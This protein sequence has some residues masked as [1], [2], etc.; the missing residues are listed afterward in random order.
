MVN[1]TERNLTKIKIVSF[2]FISS[3]LMISA[4]LYSQTPEFLWVEQVLDGANDNGFDLVVD[5]AGHTVICGNYNDNIF[6]AKYSE[7]GSLLWFQE[8]VGGGFDNGYAVAVDEFDNIYLTGNFA[9]TVVFGVGQSRETSLTSVTTSDIFVAKYDASGEFRWVKA[10]SDGGHTATGT[11]IAIDFN[12]DILVTGRFE[13]TI[14]FE[15]GESDEITLTTRGAK[16]FFI[17]KYDASGDLEWVNH[18]GGIGQDISTDIE[19]NGFGNHL[20]TGIFTDTIVFGFGGPN[21]TTLTSVGVQDLFLASYDL[22]GNFLWARQAHGNF[23]AF[24]NPSMVVQNSNEIYITGSFSDSA[25]FGPNENNESSINA[26]GTFELFH[27]RFSSAGDFLWVTQTTGSDVTINYDVTTDFHGNSFITGNFQGTVTFGVGQPNE[28][29]F[30]NNGGS[31]SFD[32]FFAQYDNN[33][34]LQLAQTIP[35][36]GAGLSAARA[37]AIDDFSNIFLTGIFFGEV[38]FGDTNLTSNAGGNI[39]VAKLGDLQNNIDSD[40]DG[41]LDIWETN[42]IDI[43][44]D[45]NIDLDL[46]ALGADPTKKD[47]FVEFDYMENH[48]PIVGMVDSVK[49]AFAM[50]PVDSGIALHIFEGEQ[51]PENLDISLKDDY[52]PIKNSYFGTPDDRNSSNAEAIL[53]ARR[54][55]FHYCL[56]AHRYNDSN[57]SG[58]SDGANDFIVTLGA[59][60]WGK[61]G[62]GHSVGTFKEQAGTFMHELGHDL[63]LGHGG[64]QYVL[65]NDKWEVINCKPN[66]LSVMNYLFQT[67][68]IPNRERLG[69]RL[70]FSREKLPTLVE[71]SLFEEDGIGDGPDR[72][73]WSPDGGFSLKAGWGDGPLNWDGLDPNPDPNPV[74]IDINNFS[75]LSSNFDTDCGGLGEEL[76]G[77]DDWVNLDFNFRDNSGYFTGAGFDTTLVELTDVEAR[78]FEDS[79]LTNT[80]GSSWNTH[81]KKFALDQNFPNPFN[82]ETQISFQIPE[83]TKVEL[84]IFDVLGREI[85]VVTNKIYEAGRHSLTWNATDNRG[86][87]VASGV[88]FY[89]LK[90]TD[91][92]QVRNMFLLE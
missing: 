13:E 32:A 66:Y 30:T 78:L 64:D 83:Q 56:F 36:S 50:A 82:S 29:T 18:E 11:G 81:L 34:N 71:A 61:D 28:I 45:G 85:R 44:G 35:V 43:N 60:Q 73:F 75:N 37:I 31:Q 39:F 48:Y 38:V 25:T 76:Q 3:L 59:S 91:F 72:T 4:K 17:A 57:S 2:V 1:P 8:V 90:A 22:L 51:I 12:N 54:R 58:Y 14:V 79:T 69:N 10:I 23:Y 67:R 19:I 16:D 5:N 46:A 86:F 70:D 33:G 9:L 88:Y 62:N 55:V 68:W 65:V 52:L 63:G 41:L 15:P 77:F 80:V 89:R 53:A 26:V 7:G 87:Q 6:T 74:S 49:A 27:A 84:K 42:G 21:D 92:A 20:V 40:G 24:L 47:I